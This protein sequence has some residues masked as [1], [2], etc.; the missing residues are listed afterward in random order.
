MSNKSNAKLFSSIHRKVLNSRIDPLKLIGHENVV[1]FNSRNHYFYFI[2]LQFF[3]AE[4]EGNLLLSLSD[5]VRNEEQQF[6]LPSTN[7]NVT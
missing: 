7:T 5:E 2:R 4:L 3:V 6:E 1:T